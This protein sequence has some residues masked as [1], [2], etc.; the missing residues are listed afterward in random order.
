MN[1]EELVAAMAHLPPSG[2]ARFS[3]WFEELMAEQ[4]DRKIESDILG[5]RLDAAGKRADE[6][7][8]AGRC[9]PLCI[10]TLRPSSGSITASY[11]MTFDSGPT[12]LYSKPI[13][14]TPNMFG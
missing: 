12:S 14:A 4:W 11:P 10:T 1:I 6:D 5:G 9:A 13:L 7:F 3:Q 2:L 8:E